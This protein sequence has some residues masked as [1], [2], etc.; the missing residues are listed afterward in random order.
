LPAGKRPAFYRDRPQPAREDIARMTLG[1]LQP[2]TLPAS[3]LRSRRRAQAR[4]TWRERAL[5]F[6]TASGM[7]IGR[8]ARFSTGQRSR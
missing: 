2:T 3:T 1:S 6:P 7:A 4:A 5:R 8:A